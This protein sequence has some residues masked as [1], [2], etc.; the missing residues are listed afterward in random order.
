M[1]SLLKGLG[2]VLL[3]VLGFVLIAVFVWYA[4]SVSLRSPTFVRS[5]TAT[6]RLIVIGIIIGLWIV[7]ALFKRLRA[8]RA[9]DKLLAAV[10]AQP[11]PEPTKTSAEAL[12]LRER[13]E[14]A[15][16]TR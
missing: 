5:E 15:V 9:S 10:V 4:G 16:A 13:F 12:K 3:I 2:R 7:S 11:N 6:A 14:E 8:C 1:F